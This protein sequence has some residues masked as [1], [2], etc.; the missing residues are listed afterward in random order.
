MFAS[1]LIKVGL[2]ISRSRSFSSSPL[3]YQGFRP[4]EELAKERY[5]SRVNEDIHTKRARL[6]YQS[7]KRGML[8]NGILLSSFADKYINSMSSEELDLYDRLINLPTNDW[9]IYYWATNTKPT[10][11]EYENAIMSKLRTY[12][13]SKVSKDE[14]E[15][16]PLSSYFGQSNP[17]AIIVKRVNRNIDLVPNISEISPTD[18]EDQLFDDSA[19]R[20][21]NKYIVRMTQWRKDFYLKR[22]R[23]TIASPTSIRHA[24]DEKRDEIFT[25][26]G[27]EFDLANQQCKTKSMDTNYDKGIKHHEFLQHLLGSKFTNDVQDYDDEAEAWAEMIWHRDYGYSDKSMAISQLVCSICR[28][29]LQC[30]DHSLPG[31]LPQ[32]LL[33]QYSH[34]THNDIECQRCKFL[35]TYE[36]LLDKE[37]SE[38]EIDHLSF[39]SARERSIV[40]ILV[41]LTDFPSGITEGIIDVVGSKHDILVVGNKIDLLPRDAH[42]Y[43]ERIKESFRNNLSKLRPNSKNLSINGIHVISARTG[44]GIDGLVQRIAQFSEDPKN[45]YLVG[46]RYSGKSTLFNALLQSDLSAQRSGDLLGRISAYDIPNNDSIKML[47]FPVNKFEGWEI[48]LKKRRIEVVER[49]TQLIERSLSSKT[50]SRQATMPHQSILID[51]LGFPQSTTGSDLVEQD[52]APNYTE[53]HPLKKVERHNPLSANEQRFDK[54][55]FFHQ[56]PSISCKNQIHDLLTVQ[57]KLITFPCE[58]FSPRKFSLRPLNS[59]FVGGLARLDLLTSTSTVIFTIYASKYLPIHVVATHKADHFYNTFLGT[60]YLGVP[61]RD[62]EGVKSWPKLESFG[63]DF[64]LVGKEWFEGVADIVLSSTGWSTVNV[65]PDQECLVRA[66]TPEARGISERRPPLLAYG[67]SSVKH[68]KKVRGTPLFE[69]R[70]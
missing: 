58:T 32:Q 62:P 35:K 70:Q 46:S 2:S 24:S 11:P 50:K 17:D 25:Q 52:D 27:M 53:D 37:I 39:I 49:N 8:E 18:Y 30:C 14:N 34:T 26:A 64:H 59:I 66:Y 20:Y 60:Q 12:I 36:V 41:D 23:R 40:I 44:F 1:R 6:L 51:R 33:S 61:I 56:T 38:I 19:K 9:D 3:I 28:S 10:P 22:L 43:I 21:G 68:V 5:E 57:E 42:G 69:R 67:K 45:I 13:N 55:T 47:R 15:R 54:H 7:R 31:Y 29:N 65:G 63:Q 4:S 16:R 48:A